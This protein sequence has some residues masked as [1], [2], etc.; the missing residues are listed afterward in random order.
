M[1][2]P[3]GNLEF[4][5][6]QQWFS[7]RDLFRVA[8]RCPHF[9]HV[10]LRKLQRHFRRFAPSGLVDGRR[11][12][13]A[14]ERSGDYPQSLL[15]LTARTGVCCCFCG[16][17]SYSKPCHRGDKMPIGELCYYRNISLND[18]HAQDNWGGGH[19][20][21]RLPYI[22]A[23]DAA[24]WELNEWCRASV[25]W[26]EW[27]KFE[28]PLAHRGPLWIPPICERCQA[29]V[30]RDAWL[31]KRDEWDDLALSRLNR[32]LNNAA[33]KKRLRENAGNAIRQREVEAFPDAY[34]KAEFVHWNAQTQASIEQQEKEAWRRGCALAERALE[35]IA[36]GD[37]PLG[38][39]V[40]A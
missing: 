36:I 7:G 4:H 13:K 20:W 15:L 32:L 39:E 3:L 22:T 10:P 29:F 5:P 17:V 1:G 2:A 19:Q 40:A 16:I 21:A 14:F 27:F 11:A 6:Q 9:D 26:P 30:V 8:L 35:R 23:W 24:C 18:P 25:R 33:Y 34:H 38:A 37:A 12:R 31:G 28:Q